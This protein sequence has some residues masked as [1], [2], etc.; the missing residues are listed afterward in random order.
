MALALV[1]GRASF[2]RTHNFVLNYVYRL[3]SL[4]K[5]WDNAVTRTA[6]PATTSPS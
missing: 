6:S 5:F 4:S 3:P 1:H 2:D